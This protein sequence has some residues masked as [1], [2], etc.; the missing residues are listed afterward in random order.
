MESIQNRANIPPNRCFF[1]WDIHYACNF[2]CTYCFF[3][4]FSDEASPQPAPVRENRSVFL[5]SIHIINY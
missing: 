3:C 5:E 4:E 1:T 2:K